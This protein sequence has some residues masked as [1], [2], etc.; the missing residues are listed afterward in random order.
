MYESNI[1]A[2]HLIT[3][4]GHYNDARSSKRGVEF[5]S[6]VYASDLNL[7]FIISER[8]NVIMV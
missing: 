1:S 4:F 6:V 8:S 3:Q 7:A 5:E 2:E